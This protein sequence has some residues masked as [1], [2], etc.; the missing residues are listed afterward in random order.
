MQKEYG[1]EAKDREDRTSSG[2]KTSTDMRRI[3]R[4]WEIPCEGYCDQPYVVQTDDAHW[5]CVMTTGPGAEGDSRQH[6]VAVR[7][8]DCGKT[9]SKPVDVEPHGPPESSWAVPLRV[10][11]GR[12]YVFYVHNSENIERLPGFGEDRRH[13]VDSLGHYVF[14]FSDDH[15]RTWSE[16]RYRV[17]I[18]AMD[19]D[20]N[21]G[22][23]GAVQFFWGVGKPL[24]HGHTVYIGVAKIG[25]FNQKGFMAESEGIFLRSDNIM[26]ESDPERIHWETLPHGDAGIRAPLG[27]IA[28]EHNLTYLDDGSLFC[29][30]RTI[31]GHSGQAYSRDEGRT[32]TP[33]KYTEYEPN[34]RRLKHPR[35][36]TFVRR[37]SCGHYLLWFHNHGQRWY[38]DRNPA[39]V[40]GGVER[41]GSIYWSQPEIVLYDDHPETRI[42]YPDF[43]EEPSSLSSPSRTAGESRYFITETQKSTARCHE[44]DPELL[45]GMWDQLLPE[46]ARRSTAFGAAGAVPGPQPIFDSVRGPGTGTGT[47]TSPDFPATPLAEGCGLT[48]EFWIRLAGLGLEEIIMTLGS[49]ITVKTTVDGT[50]QF[51]LGREAV[52]TVETDMGSLRRRTWHHVGLIVEGGPRV[53]FTLVDGVV[54]DG[55]SLRDRGWVRIP[56][57]LAK[58]GGG[59]LT[60]LP[61]KG[62]VA[63]VQGYGQPL[64]TAQVIAH[65][66]FSRF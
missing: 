9:W 29:L 45:W 21:N 25:D 50:L 27:P 37:F 23:G 54:S 11:S 46:E 51:C 42:S 66:R 44:V 26:T 30:F 41:D 48:L 31:E 55:G 14:R 5:L 59:E 61:F 35:A 4:G 33:S 58:L 3:G 8:A 7:S 40:L 32:W 63:N 38:Q 62:T 24:V 2:G 18:R 13:R 36:A 65:S 12:L 15:G 28:D 53:V 57:R 17:P 39:W 22:Y 19:I 47:S 6:I 60:C 20:R 16:K 1:T 64:R 43:V 52:T 10:A 49:D 56:P 34:G